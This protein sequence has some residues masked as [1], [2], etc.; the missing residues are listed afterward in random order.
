MGQPRERRLIA[1]YV[2]LKFP[3]RRVT[4]GCPLGPAIYRG[5]D[6]GD[7]LLALAMSRPWRLEV[8][9]L[10]VMDNALLLIEGKIQKWVDGMAKLPL[11]GSLVDATPE[12]A[13]YQGWERK[14]RLV[15]PWTMPQMEAT[16]QNL[17][18][19]LDVFAPDWIHE[20]VATLQSY[21]TRE[22]QEARQG[23]IALRRRLGVE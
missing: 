2:A 7:D 5:E 19:E 22:Y 12:L 1:E 4:L 8:D 3:D 18:V 23:K 10:V 16:A 11:Y 6:V 17:G 15:I 13:R 21:W 20:Y 9:A 14:L